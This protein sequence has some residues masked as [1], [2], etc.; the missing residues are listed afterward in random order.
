MLLA[1]I[2]TKTGDRP[3]LALSAGD[4]RLIDVLA[5][6]ERRGQGGEAEAF[7]SVKTLIEG[8]ER[9]LDALRELDE[10]SAGRLEEGAGSF[11]I[12]EAEV[13]FLPP[14]PDPEKFLCVGKNSKFHREEL[15]QTGLIKEIPQEP[16]GFIKLTSVLVGHEAEVARPDGIEEFDYEPEMAFVISKPGYRVRPE[17]ALDHV[18]GV[19]AFNDL[20]AREIQRREV[21]SGTKFWTAKNMPGFGPIGPYVATL[22]EIERPDDLWVTCHVNSELQSRFNTSDLIYQI[23]DILEHFTRYMPMNA[24]DLYATGS[25]GGVGA[26]KENPTFLKPGDIVEAG[27]EGLMTLR[28]RIVAPDQ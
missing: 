26:A 4:G 19:T 18:F 24:G 2:R 28:T 3:R 27:I 22:D 16:T 1:L 8:G 17:E 14:V 11:L 23:P 20:T 7:R 9:A 25:I 6:H 21:Q 15:V 12:K 10:W 13:E 5:A